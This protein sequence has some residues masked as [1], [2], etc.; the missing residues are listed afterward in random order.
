M[1]YLVVES[2]NQRGKVPIK[3][4]KVTIGRH[5]NNS[6]TITDEKAS[7]FH[8]EIE[9]T[10]HGFVLRDLGSRNGTMMG[11]DRVDEHVL[12][13]GDTFFIGSTSLQ[14][15]VS[16]KAAAKQKQSKPAS[17]PPV[18]A[19]DDAHALP[20]LS[21]PLSA[22]PEQTLSRKP[23]P[24]AQGQGPAGEAIDPDAIHV[25]GDDAEAIEDEKQ[26]I[27]TLNLGGSGELG[28]VGHLAEVGEDPG[29]DASAIALQSA[30]GKT[31]HAPEKAKDSATAESL[32]VL[33]LLLYACARTHAT[34]LH[35]EPKRDAGVVRFRVDGGMVEAARLP[36]D[37]NKRLH[38]LVKVLC[39]IDISK[40]SVIQEGHFTA[41][42]P[43]RHIDYRVSY[44]PAMH[45][46]K[47]VLRILDASNAPQ[48]MRD[49]DLPDWMYTAIKKTSRQDAGLVLVCGPTGSG[50]TTTLYSVL[51][52]IDAQAR[53]VITIEDP[54]EYQIPDVTQMPVD[55]KSGNSFNALL[56]SVLRQDPD[57]IVL[58]EVRDGET[59]NTAMQAATTG[60]LVLSTIHA[61]D[62][63]G[64]VFRLLD[65]GV[66]PYLVAS[67]I[68]IILA[69]RLVRLLCP[70]CKVDKK[71]TPE[72]TRRMGRS[73]EGIKQIYVPGG[74]ARCFNTGFVGRHGIFELLT[75]TDDIRDVILN[76]PSIADLRKA[77]ERIV[78]TSLKE[79]GMQ[80]VAQGLTSIDEIDRVV[81]GD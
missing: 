16:A 75:A 41:T 7:R 61:K 39:E 70:N 37:T 63:I 23:Q 52:Q 20:G 28:S 33:R 57:V 38:S 56:R 24:A 31:I 62:T 14:F 32:A 59:A 81:G 47:M 45:G 65:L 49:L 40:K 36:I 76:D 15:V 21:M 2:E 48:S 55:D 25:E 60:H 67:T 77:I 80:M 1:A 43:G 71:P 11:L 54:V 44:T 72:Q 74:C 8:C 50:K 34:D 64:T 35:L 30:R 12:T 79:S 5:S 29:F 22:G 78:F 51:R 19:S 3:G 73:V 26:R 53:N 18:Q 66:E 58:G 9:R 6:V 10:P 4:S 27:K 13:E 46:Q 68:N 42:M 69:Q 17:A